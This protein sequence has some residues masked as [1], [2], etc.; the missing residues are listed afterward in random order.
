M[1][2]SSIYSSGHSDRTASV[3]TS[4]HQEIEK[5]PVSPSSGSEYGLAY[6]DSTDNEEDNEEDR[7]EDIK[8]TKTKA[9]PPPP[10]PL[11]SSILRSGSIATTNHVRFPSASEYSERS[12]I[13][14]P[15]PKSGRH[16]GTSASSVSS[17]S[18]AGGDDATSAKSNSALIAHALGLS[19]T[20]PSEYARLGGPG[21]TMGGRVARSTSGS[22]SG[23]GSGRSAYSHRTNSSIMTS[24]AKSG[25][26]E[27]E[28]PPVPLV[29]EH[30]WG[31]SKSK[32]TGR[33]KSFPK[34]SADDTG[35]KS[36]SAKGASA[37]S[38]L[39]PNR[40]NTVQVPPT[41]DKPKLV[42]R[43]RTSTQ[44]QTETVREKKERIRQLRVCLKCDKNIEDGRWIQVDDGA[45][46]CDFCWKNMY[47]P[48]VG[49][50]CFHFRRRC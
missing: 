34:E 5:R 27:E 10:L 21:S 11:T 4:R 20:P 42:A 12:A 3:I 39:A 1:T 37:A 17:S 8:S 32:S 48:K 45:V 2:S 49:S 30:P 33:Q 29:D 22:S 16:R 15:A 25:K 23:S 50:F 18:S 35:P 36:T 26:M 7:R 13:R 24:G 9:N 19:R 43:A 38:A 28:I 41:S 14:M 47:L 46:L 6:A 44:K 40:S 31:L